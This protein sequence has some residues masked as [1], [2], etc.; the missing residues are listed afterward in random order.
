MFY[1]QRQRLK[2]RKIRE[3]GQNRRFYALHPVLDSILLFFGSPRSE[4]LFIFQRG[5]P[6]KLVIL[7]MFAR[8]AELASAIFW[9]FCRIEM[10]LNPIGTT[11]MHTDVQ[12]GRLKKTLTFNFIQKCQKMAMF[13]LKIIGKSKIATSVALSHRSLFL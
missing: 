6:K 1:N 13:L 5:V 7:L 12:I 2:S 10:D 3:H 11:M 8:T 9:L 4:T